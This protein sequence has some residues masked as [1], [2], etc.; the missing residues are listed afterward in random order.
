MNLAG[1]TTP[2]QEVVCS[3][4]GSRRAICSISMEMEEPARRF[5]WVGVGFDCVGLSVIDGAWWWM[6][7]GS[8]KLLLMMWRKN[9]EVDLLPGWISDVIVT[10]SSAGRLAVDIRHQTSSRL[11]A[12]RLS[13]INLICLSHQNRWYWIPTYIIYT[14]I[15]VSLFLM[16]VKNSF[17]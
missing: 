8:L 5:S 15:W 7:M 16:K 11:S 1:E 6:V 12:I 14:Q 9:F 3:F 13:P 10:S 17:A 2:R 4:G